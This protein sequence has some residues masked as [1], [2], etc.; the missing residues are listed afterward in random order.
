METLNQ[1][2]GESVSIAS[3]EM[4]LVLPVPLPV[5]LCIQSCWS[6]SSGEHW[7][8]LKDRVSGQGSLCYLLG[9]RMWAQDWADSSHTPEEPLPLPQP[10]QCRRECWHG[11]IAIMG[12]TPWW[13]YSIFPFPSP[14][15]SP[16]EGASPH[17]WDQTTN[18]AGADVG[19]SP[20]FPQEA[21]LWFLMP[22]QMH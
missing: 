15:R 18:Q 14:R 9:R 7:Y 2:K 17:G 16:L 6:A 12:W 3:Q 5:L 13:Q 19:P 22:A 4:F 21:H 20:Q 11:V 8:I 10:M 1:W